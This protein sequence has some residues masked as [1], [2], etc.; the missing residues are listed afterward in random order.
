MLLGNIVEIKV[1]NRVIIAVEKAQVKVLCPIQ[2]NP[3]LLVRVIG[4]NFVWTDVVVFQLLLLQ[5]QLFVLLLVD[6][7]SID[8][9]VFLRP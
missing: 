8:V 3:F 4:G 6:L 5:Q 2:V 9:L 1:C 7:N